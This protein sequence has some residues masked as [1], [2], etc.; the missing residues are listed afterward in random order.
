MPQ[1]KQHNIL[2]LNVKNDNTS[3]KLLVV[4]IKCCWNETKTKDK[5][6]EERSRNKGA[7]NA[8]KFYSSD[9]KIYSPLM[10]W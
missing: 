10:G 7:W 4:Q 2:R 5:I 6:S 1:K 8:V 9:S 3:V